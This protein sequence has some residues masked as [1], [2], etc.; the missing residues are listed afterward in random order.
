MQAGFGHIEYQAMKVGMAAEA[1]CIS[2][3]WTIIPMLVIGVQDY[4]AAGQ[5]GGGEQLEDV[6]AGSSCLVSAYTSNPNLISSGKLRT[7]KTFGLQRLLQFGSFT[8][9]CCGSRLCCYRSRRWC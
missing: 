2:R 1:A 4:A 8:P 6:T 7:A 9:C 5:V 3:P